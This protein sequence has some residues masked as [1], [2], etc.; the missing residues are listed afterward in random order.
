[1]DRLVGV[2]AYGYDWC[3]ELTVPEAAERMVRQGVDWALVQNQ[4]D[5]LPGS[6]VDQQPPAGGYT[7][8]AFREALGDK[9]IR[10]FQSTSVF[11]DPADFA[12]HPALRPVDQ[13]GRTFE[14]FGW[15][16][17]VCPS[18]PKR[19]ERKASRIAEVT[20]SLRPDGIFLSFIRFPGFWELWMPETA[21]AG[22]AEYCFC[23]RCLDRF[24][25]E[26]GHETRDPRTILHDLRAEW[27][28]WKCAVIAET[29]GV[30][31]AAAM[32]ADPTITVLLNGFGLGRPDF[33]NA[34]E[35]VLAQRFAD[36]DPYV[37]HYELMFYFQIQRR[38]PGEYIR[39]RIA[40]ARQQTSRTLLACL[41]GGAE[42]LEPEY[43]PGNRKRAITDADFR[44]ALKAG[45]EAD[46]VLVYSWRDLLAD[47][48]RVTALLDYK[49][50]SL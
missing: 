49:N 4:L 25:A 16:V 48:T 20:S 2:K 26:T 29:A 21:R 22:I 38:E 15:Y 24:T 12:A 6:A 19:L 41:Q 5:P 30:L 10:V 34:V 23:A 11:F 42:Y 50:G 8:L 1:M 14:P 18:D 17:G 33:G 40:E 46:G 7:D 36:L 3:D 32:E 9:D 27:T 31:R 47:P 44:A 39:R 43:L 13:H 28:A 37:D 35:E 45:T